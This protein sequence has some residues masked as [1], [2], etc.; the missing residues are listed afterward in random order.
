MQF[1]VAVETMPSVRPGTRVGIVDDDVLFRTGA[2]EVIC[3]DVSMNLA[4]V[5]ATVQDA[6][7]Q[8]SVVDVVRIGSLNGHWPALS[9]SDGVAESGCR[10]IMLIDDQSERELSTYWDAGISL[11]LRREADGPGLVKAIMRAD[12]MPGFDTTHRATVLGEIG[13]NG[14]GRGVRV[15]N[16]LAGLETLNAREIEIL[17]AIARGV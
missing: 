4:F 8:T 11:C 13:S 2:A 5:L 3:D 10:F 14:H 17:D 6:S 12:A 7:T 16:D 1:F 15:R 9:A